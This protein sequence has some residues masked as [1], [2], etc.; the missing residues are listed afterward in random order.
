MAEPRHVSVLLHECI[1]NLKIRPDGIY[2][3]GTLGLGGHSFEIASRLTTGRLI[4]IDRDETAIERAG[5]RLACF[6]ETVTLVHGNFSD[7]A[8]ILSE[9]G[10]EDERYPIKT[11]SDDELVMVSGPPRYVALVKDS[12]KRAVAYKIIAFKKPDEVKTVVI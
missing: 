7:A 11:A 9:L 12:G 10:V 2:L 8:G 4:G 3:D 6:G 1:D 5:R